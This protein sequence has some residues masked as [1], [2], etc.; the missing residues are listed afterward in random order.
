MANSSMMMDMMKSNAVMQIPNVVMMGSLTY[1]FSGFVLVQ[2]PFELLDVFRGMLQKGIHLNNLDVRYVTSLSWYILVVF[3][4][5][6]FYALIL[7]EENEGDESKLMSRQMMSNT[8]GGK[9]NMSQLF[10]NSRDKLKELKYK[11]KLEDIK[12]RFI[13][14]N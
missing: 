6:N 1:F 10:Q 12:N 8:G 5:K 11:N 4:L 7:G 9:V 2:I 3:G 13:Q 14:N